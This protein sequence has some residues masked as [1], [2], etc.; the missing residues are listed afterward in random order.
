MSRQP[1]KQH[2]DAIYHVMAKGNQGSYIFEDAY[3]KRHFLG[4]LK[5]GVQ[6]FDVEVYAFC[7]M[8]NHY[9][10]LLRTREANLSF[11]MHFIGS[12]YASRLRDQGHIGHIFSGRYKSVPIESQRH[13]LFV[14]RYIHINPQRA[15]IVEYPEEYPWSSCM[16]HLLEQGHFDWVNRDFVLGM[17]SPSLPS[18]RRIYSDF[19]A[20]P[21]G[22][23]HEYPVFPENIP[24]ARS[25]FGAER[26]VGTALPE[27][28]WDISGS[29]EKLY[30]QTCGL[31]EKKSLPEGRTRSIAADSARLLFVFAARE[32]LLATNSEV[33]R[34]LN[35]M[36][37]SSV[38]KYYKKAGELLAEGAPESASLRGQL[39]SIVRAMW[40]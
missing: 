23:G 38:S 7:I 33:G 2:K 10:L 12:S 28:A 34:L 15:G 1:R 5:S 26:F 3:N 39:D 4:F 29:L 17:L 24:L 27:G 16:S 31:F 37:I 40:P 25:I 32:Y 19:L 35:G 20:D 8:G 11:L 9:H 13:A 36:S 22:A 14:S 30:G 18:S 6:R 21:R